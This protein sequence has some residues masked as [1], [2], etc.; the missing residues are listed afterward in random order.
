MDGLRTPG[1]Q[2][3]GIVGAGTI[4]SGLS[5]F[6]PQH[7]YNILLCTR[8][9]KNAVEAYHTRQILALVERGVLSNQ[10][11]D[12]IR[13]RVS[14]TGWYEDLADCQLVIESIVEDIEA[15]KRVLD[16]LSVLC[17]ED[18]ILASTTSSIRISDL[19]SSVHAPERF[20]GLHFFNPVARMALVEV[21]AG[22]HTSHRSLDQATTFVR[23]IEKVP[24]LVNDV[25]GFIVNR[26]ALATCNRA[27][28]LIEANLA[29]V[30]V[31]DTGMKLGCA[32]PLGPLEL[33][34]AIGWDIVLASLEN[35]LHATGDLAYEPRPL[36]R[37]LVEQGRLGRKVGRGIYEYDEAGGR[38]LRPA[39]DLLDESPQESRR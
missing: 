25:A 14:V 6:L 22:N 27:L 18:S 36:L 34:D 2:R 24:L 1:V 38:R 5:V 29:T 4:G 39:L 17:P 21:I 13:E 32:H 9:E 31:I 15:K 28:S 16:R 33:G 3:I 12:E 26:L 37:R 7:G 23:S 30:D 19:S 8:R 11:A 20:L 35:I 10:T